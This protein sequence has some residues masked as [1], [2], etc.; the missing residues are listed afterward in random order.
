MRNSYH[1]F[2]IVTRSGRVARNARKFARLFESLD[3]VVRVRRHGFGDD[4]KRHIVDVRVILFVHKTDDLLREFGRED[5]KVIAD[6]SARKIGKDIDDDF[7][8][9][10]Q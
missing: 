4:G 3:F 1:R 8:Q 5:V 2:R 6:Q 9:L 10:C 7:R